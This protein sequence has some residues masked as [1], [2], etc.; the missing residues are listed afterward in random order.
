VNLTGGDVPEQLR[1]AQVTA[2]YF[3][4]FGA[5][6]ILGRGFTAEEDRPKRAV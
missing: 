3:R 4:L 1:S 6:I 5:P 2:G